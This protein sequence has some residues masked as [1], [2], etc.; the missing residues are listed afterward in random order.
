M[1]EKAKSLIDTKME[2]RLK[3][4]IYSNDQTFVLSK[5]KKKQ[6]VS[7]KKKTLFFTVG[8]ELDSFTFW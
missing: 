1:H 5:N 7:L 4:I 3:E 6:N 2:T 8:M